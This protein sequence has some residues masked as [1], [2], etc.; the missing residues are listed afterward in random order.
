MSE[1]PVDIL[2]VEDD[3]SLRLVLQDNLEEEG[4]RVVAVATAAEARQ[5]AA[6]HRFELLI[7]DIMLPDQDGYSLCEQLRADGLDARVLMLT[8]RSLE[9][10]LVRGFDAGADD[11]LRKPYRLREL[12]ARVRA[13]L[14]RRASPA[15]GTLEF[16]GYRL[17]LD[18]RIV[19]APGGAEVPL[20]RTEFDLLSLLVRRRGRALTRNDIL[21]EVWGPGLVVDPRT[22]DNFISSLKRKLGWHRRAGFRIHTVRG[23]GYRLEVDE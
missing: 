6:R 10:D 21:D 14:R 18:A 3:E 9:D 12:L 5:A 8:A 1:T 16:A 17:D 11:Y 7:L 23:V 4:F 13:L 20:T 22:V 19:T 2:I 15:V